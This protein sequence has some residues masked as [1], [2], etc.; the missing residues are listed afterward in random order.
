MP[1]IGSGIE[2]RQTKTITASIT[3]STTMCSKINSAIAIPVYD[4]YNLYSRCHNHSGVFDGFAQ[5]TRIVPQLGGC[6]GMTD[7]V[8]AFQRF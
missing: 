6:P 1:A 7:V 2:K 3:H 8:V 4:Y 5:R